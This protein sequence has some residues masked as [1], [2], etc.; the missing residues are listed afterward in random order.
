MAES[1]VK[2]LGVTPIAKTLEQWVFAHMISRMHQLAVV[3]SRQ[4]MDQRDRSTAKGREE[5]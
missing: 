1:P 3:S 5:T 2:N 4:T